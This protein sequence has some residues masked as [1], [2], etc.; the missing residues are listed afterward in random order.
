MYKGVGDS[1]WDCPYD[2]CDLLFWGTGQ[3]WSPAGLQ[4][5]QWANYHGLDGR[6]P[7]T[8]C[9]SARWFGWLPL[10]LDGCRDEP[11]NTFELV[12]EVEDVVSGPDVSRPFEWC[13]KLFPAWSSKDIFGPLFCADGSIPSFSE[14]WHHWDVHSCSLVLCSVLR[15]WVDMILCV[16]TL[17]SKDS[18]PKTW[19]LR[20][21]IFFSP[22]PMW[23]W[24]R[25]AWGAWNISILSFWILHGTSPGL[26]LGL[27]IFLMG[28]P[29]RTRKLQWLLKPKL[30][31]PRLPK[32]LAFALLHCSLQDCHASAIFW[33]HTWSPWLSFVS[34]DVSSGPGAYVGG[35][36][37]KGKLSWNNQ[38]AYLIPGTTKQTNAVV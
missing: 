29:D 15:G 28:V 14:F 25:K 31:A 22:R 8:C 19:T 5:S 34:T 13:W 33:S 17:Q 26:S 7:A 2:T 16:C 12:V 18:S 11:W 36:S 35:C 10:A 6:H 20:C 1:L 9:V 32:V 23:F 37:P 3:G 27:C 4:S 30:H 24:R 21:W 38:I